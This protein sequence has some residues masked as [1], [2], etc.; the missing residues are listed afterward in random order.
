MKTFKE[1]YITTLGREDLDL[2]YPYY[3]RVDQEEPNVVTRCE[4]TQYHG[5]ESLEL[6]ELQYVCEVLRQRGANRVYIEEH[7]DYQGYIFVGVKLEELK[8]DNN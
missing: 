5:I 4:E 2:K 7:S 8:D 6:S 1:T 3:D